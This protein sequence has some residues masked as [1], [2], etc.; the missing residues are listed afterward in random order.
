MYEMYEVTW[1]SSFKIIILYCQAKCFLCTLIDSYTYISES[2]IITRH[3]RSGW[4]EHVS[5]YPAEAS[6]SWSIWR[7]HPDQDLCSSTRSS[8]MQDVHMSFTLFVKMS[9]P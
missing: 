9:K 5:E 8:L 4:N 7:V 6:K 2:S 1:L 3:I